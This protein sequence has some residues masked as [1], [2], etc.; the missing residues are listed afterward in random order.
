MGR[1]QGAA[2]VLAASGIRSEVDLT[3]ELFALTHPE[4]GGGELEKTRTTSR[5]PG[6]RSVAIM[7]DQS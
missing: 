6:V 5:A 1:L 3:D 7:R 4:L 2:L